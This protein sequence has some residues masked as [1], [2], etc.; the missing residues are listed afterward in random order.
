VKTKAPFAVIYEDEYIIAV[1]KTSGLSVCGD[2]WDDSKERLDLLIAHNAGYAKIFTVHRVDRDTSG[3]VIFAKNEEIHRLLSLAFE[4]RR[5]EKRYIAVARGRPPW[6]ET[7]CDLPLV[8]NGN[9]R[10]LTIIDKY[11]GKKSLT[12]FR[13]LGAAGMYSVLEA[14]P[15]TGRTHQIRV[16]ASALGFPI[17][18]DPLYGN[19]KPVLLSSFKRGWRGDPLE[20]KPLLARLGLHAAELALPA[21]SGG[22]AG[23]LRFSAP[24]PRDMA[25]LVTQMEKQGLRTCP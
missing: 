5:V 19:E 8:P 18:C 12:H 15:E 6:S 21:L 7:S 22:D 17:V 4:G 13:L 10:H 9:K 16:H 20:E 2:R 1:N 25:A 3:L 14:R 23:P 11:R 24:L